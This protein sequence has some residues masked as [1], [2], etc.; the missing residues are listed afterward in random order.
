MQPATFSDQPEAQQF[1]EIPE[2]DILI[3]EDPAHQA[4]QQAVQQGEASKSTGKTGES[5]QAVDNPTPEGAEAGAD[6][7]PAPAEDPTVE[8]K[9]GTSTDPTDT[10][11]PQ[12]G[13]EL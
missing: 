13:N 1:K 12:D 5:S 11:K 10:Q 9:P 4:A 8:P 3:P 6:A 2:E 7:P